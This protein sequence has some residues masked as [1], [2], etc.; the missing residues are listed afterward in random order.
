MNRP[1]RS[2]PQ[3]IPRPA[4]VRPGGGPPWPPRQQAIT[5]QE[6]RDAFSGVGPPGEL[7]A[8]LSRTVR[9]GATLRTSSPAAVLVPLFSDDDRVAR[10]VL[11][12]RAPHLRSHTHQVAFPGGRLDHGEQPLAAALRE[13]TE[14]VGLDPAVVHVIGQ[15]S[16][17]ETMSSGASI[18]PFVGVLPGRPVLRPNPAEVE[19]VFDVALSDLVDPDVYREEIWPIPGVGER[20]MW[21]YEL[22][23]DTVWGAT[24]R[25]LTELL[26]LVLGVDSDPVI[27]GRGTP[28]G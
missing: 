7:P 18:I 11:T 10:V 19:A 22:D 14:E 21:L 17:L 24:A 1:K 2:G 4:G 20:T 16:P 15:L 23:G 3:V 5:L 28:G 9:D 27:T 13:A 12:R 8:E 25:M 26:D 6:V